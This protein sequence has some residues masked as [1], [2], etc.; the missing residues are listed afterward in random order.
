[1]RTRNSACEVLTWHPWPSVDAQWMAPITT[2]HNSGDHDIS[3][4]CMLQRRHPGGHSGSARRPHPALRVSGSL[5]FWRSTQ[6]F[7]CSPSRGYHA[8][9]YVETSDCQV[10]LMGGF[11]PSVSPQS[12]CCLQLSF[13]PKSLWVMCWD[14]YWETQILPPA[15][16]SGWGRAPSDPASQVQTYWKSSISEKFTQQFFCGFFFN[17]SFKC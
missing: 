3:H 11:L 16:P 8:S 12:P 14:S 5:L 1:M 9:Y 2:V 17:L 7:P 13:P 10:F 6:Q 4:G 15:P